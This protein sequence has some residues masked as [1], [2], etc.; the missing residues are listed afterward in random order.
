MKPIC[1]SIIIFITILTACSKKLQPDI[2]IGTIAVK[3]DIVKHKLPHPLPNELIEHLSDFTDMFIESE[4]QLQK[5]TGFKSTHFAKAEWKVYIVQNHD[6]WVASIVITHNNKFVANH[7]WSP[8]NSDGTSY[9][10]ILTLIA[11]TIRQKQ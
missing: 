3:T 4:R 2:E 9:T 10:D 8:R 7:L 5:E 6:I 11:D 1:L